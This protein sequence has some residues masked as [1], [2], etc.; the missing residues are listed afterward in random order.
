MFSDGSA[1]HLLLDCSPLEAAR[2]KNHTCVRTCKFLLV[3]SVRVMDQEER[4]MY[5]DHFRSILRPP[6]SPEVT[7]GPYY[8]VAGHPIRQNI[9][10]DQLGLLF[11]RCNLSF[12]RLLFDSN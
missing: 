11:V 4:R 10:E 1:D 6:V 7:Q 5:A 12:F 3:E 8:H 2:I 9:A